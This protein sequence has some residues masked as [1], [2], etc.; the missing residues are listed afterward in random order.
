[1][2][3]AVN[4][5][6]LRYFEK[7]AA[8]PQNRENVLRAAED[9]F[10]ELFGTNRIEMYADTL[11]DLFTMNTVVQGVQ[12]DDD[13]PGAPPTSQSNTIM[14]C[15]AHCAGKPVCISTK[16]QTD[17]ERWAVPFSDESGKLY[18]MALCDVSKTP[19]EDARAGAGRVGEN[20]ASLLCYLRQKERQE[21]SI[22]TKMEAPDH[23]VILSHEIKTPLTVMLSALQ[24]LRPKLEQEG[25]SGRVGN[26]GQS[27]RSL[28]LDVLE[29]SIYKLQRVTTNILDAQNLEMGAFQP[30]NE[31]IDLVAF[32][33][34]LMGFVA[35]YATAQKVS[36]VF[37]NRGGKECVAYLAPFYLDRILLNLLS[38]AL[39]HT[40]EGGCVLVRLE[41]DDGMIRIAVENDGA[42]I[43]EETL[44][45][46]FE[47]YWRG[48]EK[49]GGAGLGLYLCQSFAE[50]IKGSLYA[51]N[52]SEGGARF[53]LT[54]PV[55]GFSGGISHSF[56]SASKPYAASRSDLVRV[57][58]STLLSEKCV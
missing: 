16:G 6:L 41:S 45:H 43:P 44:E 24:L 35:P 31:C 34:E 37:E 3:D 49:Q 7:A 53:A 46:M 22:P 11:N 56:F 58:L 30:E 51:E 18:G 12:S 36:L 5:A 26:G 27:G 39:Q 8:P 55:C 15:L 19:D 4:A 25:K 48:P 52:R 42:S 28:Y 14:A 40:K 29:V 50:R 38:N 32:L 21:R 47:K 23:A 33:N 54:F 2:S 13:S 1:M 57:E 9:A 20:L 17:V 10:R